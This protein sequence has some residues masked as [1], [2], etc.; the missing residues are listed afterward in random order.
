MEIVKEYDFFAEGRED[1]YKKFS[2]KSIL[3]QGKHWEMPPLVTILITTYKRPE[4]LRQALE[5]ALNQK[6]F[7]DYQ[8]IVADNE[9]ASIEEETPTARLMKEY[10]NEKL[11]YYRHSQEVFYK[12]DSA[13]RLARSQWIVFLHDDDLLAENHLRLMT[14]IVK[15]HK[16]IKFLGCRAKDFILEKEIE[17]EKN[18]GRSDRYVI[19][20]CLKSLGCLGDWVGWL[21]ALISRKHYISI[22]GMP[23]VSMGCGDRAMV[24]KFLH[25][26]GTYTCISDKPLYYYRRGRQQVSYAKKAEWERALINEYFFNK[27]VINKYHKFTHRIWEKNMAY[28]ILDLCRDYNKGIYHTQIDLKHVI[29]ECNMPLDLKR[30]N[31]FFT[32]FLIDS[33]KNFARILDYICINVLK[34]TD[35]HIRV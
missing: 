32:K 13:V 21:G 2:H 7:Y 14:G 9:G 28:Y 6:G 12:A 34:N 16:E 25:Y 33:Y 3:C 27:Y 10:P 22:G 15:K 35:I 19:Q 18:R 30:K 20:R 23:L 1:F 29:F 8:I 5:S 17:K 4:M 24:G 26:Y 31:D 11:I